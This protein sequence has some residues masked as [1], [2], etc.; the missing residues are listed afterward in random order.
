MATL[1]T[2]SGPSLAPPAGVKPDA[3]VVFL[4]GV[5]ADGDDLIGLAPHVRH[6]LPGAFFLSPHAPYPFDMA[7]QGRQWFSI[8]EMTGEARLDG[9]IRAAPLLDSFI[10]AKLSELG[11]AP[12]R[13]V[14][15]GFS[16]GTM[17]ALHV[18]PR[19]QERIGAILGYSGLLAGPERLG[20]D[21]RSK[22]PVLLVHGDADEVLPIAALPEAQD[23]LRAVGIEVESH[24][25]PGMGHGIDEAGIGFGLDFID[26]HL[27][28][29]GNRRD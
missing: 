25:R 5:G 23:A 27:N 11:L 22:P 9:V 19:R 21:V 7:P 28:G 20:R 18:G 15:I 16:Q 6:V 8:R 10:D 17:M 4:H 3:L 14:M 24:V 29:E 12:V 26:R 2:L 13:L 1:P